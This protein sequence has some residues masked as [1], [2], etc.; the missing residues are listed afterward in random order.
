M[1]EAPATGPHQS[2]ANLPEAVFGL[3]G[4]ESLVWEA[5]RIH[6][7]NQR[8]GNACTKTRAEVSGTGKKPFRQKHTGRARQG[9]RRAPLYRGGGI[10]FGPRPRDYRLEMPKQKRRQALKLALSAKNQA[11]AVIVLDDIALTQPKTKELVGTLRAAGLTG[12]VL[13]LPGT[14]DEALKRASHN[15]PWLTVLPSVQVHPYAVLS[16]D[17]VVFTRSGLD[18]FLAGGGAN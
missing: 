12:S 11:G 3:K 15:V 1:S 6:L 9:S 2:A 7:A 16:H 5:V 14:V 13:L 4:S 10:V 8:E 17:R 18:K